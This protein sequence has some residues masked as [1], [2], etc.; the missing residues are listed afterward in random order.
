MKNVTIN[1]KTAAST[2]L[3]A[4][5]VKNW[6]TLNSTICGLFYKKWTIVIDDDRDARGVIKIIKNTITSVM[7]KL[8]LR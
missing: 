8:N 5:F 7:T 2:F 3:R 6:A 1:V 4:T